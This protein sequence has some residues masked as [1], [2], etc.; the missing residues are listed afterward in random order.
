MEE[1]LPLQLREEFSQQ[2]IETKENLEKIYE[3]KTKGAILRS[4]TRWYNE[5]EKNS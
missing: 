4:K 2:L 5:G 3:Y 1:L